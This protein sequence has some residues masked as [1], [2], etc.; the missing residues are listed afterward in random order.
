ME[1]QLRHV[2]CLKEHLSS[3]D[4]VA[5]R[6]VRWLSEKHGMLFRVHFQVIEDVSPNCFHLFPIFYD[7][8]FNWVAQ[9]DQAF[10]FFLSMH[11][12]E[13]MELWTQDHLQLFSQ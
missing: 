2:K 1:E 6:V 10:E 5:D 12:Y 9:F 4:S 11:M 13:Y 3:S 8:M 7:S